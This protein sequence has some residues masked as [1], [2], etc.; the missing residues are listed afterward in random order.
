MEKYHLSYDSIKRII[1]REN[2]KNRR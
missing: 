2:A 1:R